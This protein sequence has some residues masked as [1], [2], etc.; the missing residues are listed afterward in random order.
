MSK[1]RRGV[2]ENITNNDIKNMEVRRDRKALNIA[3][4]D[5]ERRQFEERDMEK[6]TIITMN[7][8]D[9]DMLN[10]YAFIKLRLSKPIKARE[11]GMLIINKIGEFI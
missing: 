10:D 7:K 2:F 1:K 6:V 3:R 8:G 5:M 11:L 9:D 4:A